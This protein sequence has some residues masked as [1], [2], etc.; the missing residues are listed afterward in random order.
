MTSVRSNNLILKC[1]MFT[2]SHFKDIKFVAKT[3]LFSNKIEILMVNL[4]NSSS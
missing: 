4:N 2:P 3:Q 1:K